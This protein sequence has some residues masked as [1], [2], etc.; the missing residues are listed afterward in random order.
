M[1]LLLDFRITVAPERGQIVRDLNRAM[2]WG[3]DLDPQGHAARADRETAGHAV[4]ILDAGGDR[5]RL[6]GSV[7]DFGI[8]LVRQFDAFWSELVQRILLRRV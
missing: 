4:E 5:R 1:Q 7:D 6:V 3:Q 2:I 8:A